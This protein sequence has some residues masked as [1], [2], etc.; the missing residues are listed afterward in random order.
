MDIIEKIKTFE[1]A[2]A[3]VPVKRQASFDARTTNDSPDEVAYKKI[4]IIA[5]ALNEGWKPDWKNS[6]EYKYYPWFDFEDDRGSGLGLSYLDYVYDTRFRL[7]GLAF[8]SKRVAW[9]VMPVS[10]L[11]RSTLI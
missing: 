4:K 5:N 6:D 3:K 2:L 8:A 11:H 10:S 9:L 1:D 7:S